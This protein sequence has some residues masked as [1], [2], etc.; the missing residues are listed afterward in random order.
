MN[1]YIEVAWILSILTSCCSHA[2]ASVLNL[3]LPSWKKMMRS[4]LFAVV[5][6]CCF[7]LL[8]KLY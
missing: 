4:L 3:N 6:V 2:L 8:G 7:I 5:L 1:S